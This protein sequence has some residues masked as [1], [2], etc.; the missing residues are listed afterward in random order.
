M[1]SLEE[2][3]E[4]LKSEILG[5]MKVYLDREEGDYGYYLVLL[6]SSNEAIEFMYTIN[7]VYTLI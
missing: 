4:S 7:M 3:L 5:H 2:S 6:V 1:G